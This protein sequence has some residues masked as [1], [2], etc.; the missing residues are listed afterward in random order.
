MTPYSICLSLSP[1]LGLEHLVSIRTS[2]SISKLVIG[3]KMSNLFHCIIYYHFDGESHLQLSEGKDSG[4][5]LNFMISFQ[6]C[7]MLKFCG[8]LDFASL[9]PCKHVLGS[10]V[11]VKTQL[12]R[13]I[14]G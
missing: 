14:G 13:S 7:H 3:Y 12:P 9:F 8:V 2:C 1:V 10:F 6:R 4:I 11:R 5:K